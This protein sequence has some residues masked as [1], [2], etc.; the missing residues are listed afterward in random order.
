MMSG[1]GVMEREIGR[2]D[3]WEYEALIADGSW[4][5]V[6]VM[7]AIL[8]TTSNGF[9]PGQNFCWALLVSRSARSATAN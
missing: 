8:R 5:D 2:A 9:R 6:E 3:A 7:A 4:R 1:G